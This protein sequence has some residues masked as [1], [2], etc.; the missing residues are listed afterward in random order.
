MEELLE[1]MPQEHVH[2][3]VEGDIE[4]YISVPAPKCR[5]VPTDSELESVC[6]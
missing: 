2:H 5:K 6:Y 1:D 4:P 3:L